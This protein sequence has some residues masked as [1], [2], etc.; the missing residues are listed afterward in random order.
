MTITAFPARH[1][2]LPPQDGWADALPLPDELDREHWRWL[3]WKRQ[4]GGWDQP[5]WI[6]L[7]EAWR[8]AIDLNHPSPLGPGSFDTE[9]GNPRDALYCLFCDGWGELGEVVAT[10]GEWTVERGP[11]APCGPCGGTGNG[12]ELGVAG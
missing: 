7:Q 12:F 3:G 11:F 5:L 10:D 8:H 1:D 2:N 9:P 6:A 4:H